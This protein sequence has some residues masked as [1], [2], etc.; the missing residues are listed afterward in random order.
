MRGFLPAVLVLLLGLFS[1]GSWVLWVGPGKLTP[2]SP[3]RAVL[4]RGVLL[5]NC[6]DPTMRRWIGG[7][8][9]HLGVMIDSAGNPKLGWFVSR[10]VWSASRLKDVVFTLEVHPHHVK[11]PLLWAWAVLAAPPAGVML[12][13][14]WRRRPPEYAC[15]G[16]GYDLRGM[17]AGGSGGG[18]CP[19]C[20][21]APE[22]A[23]GAPGGPGSTGPLE[24]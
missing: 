14:R 10:P 18:V 19:E 1:A 13:R 5:V 11:I 6:G 12:W 21:A 15:R 23:R 24:R 7:R 20:G 9:W 8:T 17:P 4:T 2:T 22:R 3:P 16:C